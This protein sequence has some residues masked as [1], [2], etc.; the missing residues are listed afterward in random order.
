MISTCLPLDRYFVVTAS[1]A[2]TVEAS[3]ICEADMSI[4]MLRG[5]SV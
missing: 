5:S 3:Q 2:A 1:R 4:T